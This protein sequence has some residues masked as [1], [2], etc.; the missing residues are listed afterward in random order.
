MVRVVVPASTSNLG[1]GFDVFGLALPLFLNL[2]FR[3]SSK[4][5]IEVEGE[6]EG[7]LPLDNRNLIF[8]T[9]DFFCRQLG[10]KL[11][12]LWIKVKNEIPLTRGLGSSA[13]AIVGSLIAADKLYQT[14]LSF[15]EIFQMAVECEGHADN[16][17]ASLFGGFTLS[18]QVGNTFETR[19]FQPHPDL[20]V[21]LLI[22]PFQ[23]STR[24]A[25][26]VLPNQVSL[27]DAVYNLSRAALLALSLIRG[28]W[29]N[30]KEAMKD[31]LHQP[32]R[33]KLMPE[34]ST[35]LTKLNDLP[36]VLGASLSGAGPSLV[37]LY[38]QTDE[39]SLKESV[40][41]LLFQEGLDFKLRLLKVESKGASLIEE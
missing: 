18:Y 34:L 8:R 2:E 37:G 15:K 35:L 4:F 36:A 31:K 5:K 30:I 1:S 12:P 7:R 20:R 38:K 40:E 41:S 13:A 9:L 28:D 22:P 6:G 11:V 39:I 16:I 33:E 3:T 32:Y 17:S 14:N 25:R 26:R 24:E 19:V 23:L 29:E 21:F 27:N 10:K